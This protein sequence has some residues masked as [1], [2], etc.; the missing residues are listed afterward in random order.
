MRF[1]GTRGEVELRSERHRRHS[2]LCLTVAR[3]RVLVDCGDDWLDELAELVPDAVVLTHAHRDHAGGLRHGAACPVYA[4][5]E[6]WTKIAHYPIE[7]RERVSPRTPFDILG[8]TFE[9]FPVEHSLVAPAVGYRIGFAGHVFFYAPDLVSIPEQVEALRGI[10][11]YVGDGASVTRPIVRRRDEVRIGHASIREQLDWC[12][13]ESVARAVFTHC[14][15]QILR[16]EEAAQS[17]VVALGRERGVRATIAHDGLRI[18]LHSSSPP[19]S[20]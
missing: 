3:R 6:T 12:V 19:S 1:L 9:A 8:I 17:R 4:T 16:N 7:L 20:A 2:A 18:V 10:D 11:V 13:A 15:S 5:D 14:G